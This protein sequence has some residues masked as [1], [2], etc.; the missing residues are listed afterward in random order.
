MTRRPIAL[1]ALLLLAGCNWGA[2]QP[3][4]DAVTE[5]ACRERADQIYGMRHPEATYSQDTY[6]SSLRDAPLGTSGTPSLPTQGLSSAYEHD[7]LYND[8]IRGR[9]G[10]GPTPAAPPPLAAPPAPP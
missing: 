7:R 4:A 6:T 8:C 10:A 5:A 2:P 1:L 3:H 9:A